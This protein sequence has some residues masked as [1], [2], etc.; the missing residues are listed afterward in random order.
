MTSDRRLV[1]AAG[2]YLVD[3]VLWMLFSFDWLRPAGITLMTHLAAGTLRAFVDQI[4][5]PAWTALWSMLLTGVFEGFLPLA[6]YLLVVRPYHLS[7][8]LRR[9][10]SAWMALLLACLTVVGT[11]AWT[12]RRHAPFGLASAVFLIGF[13]AIV[14]ASEEWSYRGV[15]M[16][17]LGDRIGLLGAAFAV[18]AAFGLAHVQEILSSGVAP[19]S[20]SFWLTIAED[21]AIGLLLTWVAWRSGSILWAATLHGIWDWL[22]IATGISDSHFILWLMVVALV[23]SEMLRYVSRTRGISSASA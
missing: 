22:Q 1:V 11:L 21:A 6:L 13:L 20:G 15:F 9:R 12:V 19:G 2:V 5:L 7:P 23:G 8:L 18:N 10:G 17:V 14:G 4:G 3:A 16:R